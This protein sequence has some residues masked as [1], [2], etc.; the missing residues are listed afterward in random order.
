MLRT[1]RVM[2]TPALGL[3]TLLGLTAC[4]SHNSDTGDT[5]TAADCT[6][7]IE[8]DGR[9]Y[10]AHAEMLRRP[11]LNGRVGQA[12]MLACNDNPRATPG[13]DRFDGDPFAV[14]GI[15]GVDPGS[16]VYAGDTIYL[17]RRQ[18]ESPD[19]VMPAALTDAFTRPTCVFGEP[20]EVT[21]Q[22]LGI[23]G[24]HADEDALRPPYR[25]EVAVRDSRRADLA[26]THIVVSVTRQTRP[27]LDAADIRSV[28]WRGG[29][30]TATLHCDGRRFV[31]AS[32]HSTTP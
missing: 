24:R 23:A 1:R 2:L 8:F 6:A 21:G 11:E 4:T 20:F 27:T 16:A 31:A 22:W 26:G 17:E 19:W 18:Y 12:S 10:V 3:A 7:V 13:S 15:A 9:E 30:L 5:V 25:I 28:L 29:Y 14:S 32:V